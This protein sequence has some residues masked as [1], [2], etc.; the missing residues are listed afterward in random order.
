[1]E[2]LMFAIQIEINCQAACTVVKLLFKLSISHSIQA[3]SADLPREE[4][5]S[6]INGTGLRSMFERNSENNTKDNWEL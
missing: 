4:G 2:S 5:L 1:M 6:V 3:D